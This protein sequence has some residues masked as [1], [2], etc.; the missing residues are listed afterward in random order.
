[1]LA[2]LRLAVVGCGSI[3]RHH[4]RILS[5]LEGC[6]LV[7][8]VDPDLD[9]AREAAK[10][11]G[12]EALPDL[13]GVLGKVDA[14]SVAAPTSLHREIAVR[15]LEAGADVLVEKPI[16]ATLGEADAILRAA[17]AGRVLGVG[18]VER[19][20][21][22]IEA[23]E[24]LVRKPR[25]LEIHRLG[26]FPGRSTD[27]DVILDLMIHDLDLCLHLEGRPLESVSALG[28]GVLTPGVDIANARIVFEG[29]CIANLTA[30]RVSAEKV[31]KV[32]VFQPDS[33][34]SAD[35]AQRSGEVVRLEAGEKPGV[36][37][38]ALQVRDH[39]PLRGE[40]EDFL[41]AV[42][43]RRPPRVPGED[44]RKAL[45]AA[46]RV[47]EAIETTRRRWEES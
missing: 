11:A 38:D 5:G 39:E 15:L 43:S 14:A 1:M 20:N 33:Y 34:I 35:C 4:A 16:A 44:G 13:R 27:V 29:G 37:R 25:F 10:G 45:D 30:S 41:E 47:R 7:A 32:R 23:L 9:R 17:A 40:L 18:H 21:P 26:A 12:A 22:A 8:C 28:V 6:R 24:G 36:R 3:G 31:R 42:R 19:F 46:L 2:P